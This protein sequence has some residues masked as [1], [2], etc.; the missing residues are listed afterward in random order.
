MVTTTTTTT[1][2]RTPPPPTCFQDG[3]NHSGDGGGRLGLI[4]VQVGYALCLVVGLLT[5]IALK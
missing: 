2:T 4:A 5:H 3:D 1:T